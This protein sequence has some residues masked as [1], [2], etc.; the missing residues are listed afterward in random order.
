MEQLLKQMM[1][2]M[3]QQFEK[4][5]RRFDAIDQRLDRIDQRLDVL[6][7]S[8]KSLTE[9][10]HNNASEMRSHFR[11]MEIKME[12]HDKMFEIITAGYELK[13]PEGKLPF[14]KD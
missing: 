12:R 8:M 9:T 4:I 6:E 1:E 2:Q 7:S 14:K 13:I 5:E 11:Y 3:N 10:V